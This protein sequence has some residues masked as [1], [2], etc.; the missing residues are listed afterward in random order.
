MIEALLYKPLNAAE[1]GYVCNLSSC[2]FFWMESPSYFVTIIY[3]SKPIF[4][5]VT[6][7]LLFFLETV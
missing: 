2:L 5:I 3:A 1:R 4:V 6:A 7:L